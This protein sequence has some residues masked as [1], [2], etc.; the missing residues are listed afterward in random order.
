MAFVWKQAMH[1]SY[2]AFGWTN[3]DIKETGEK[4][5]KVLFNMGENRNKECGYVQWKDFDL[6]VT[7]AS[8]MSIYWR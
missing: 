7:H 6:P 4:R 1:W 2:L 5:Y 3:R 8:V